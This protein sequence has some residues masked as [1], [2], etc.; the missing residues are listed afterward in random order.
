AQIKAPLI[1]AAPNVCD[2]TSSHISQP[3]PPNLSLINQVVLKTNMSKSLN[4]SFYVKSSDTEE[5]SSEEDD[6]F[7]TM[8]LKSAA[9]KRKPKALPKPAPQPESKYDLF[10]LGALVKKNQE[11]RAAFQSADKHFAEA[12]KDLGEDEGEVETK[13]SDGLVE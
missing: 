13:G 11:V 12:E 2:C 4:S 9:P 3:L 6:L 7:A 1:P 10:K 5:E 8:G